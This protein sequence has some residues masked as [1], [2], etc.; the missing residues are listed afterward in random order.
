[1]AFGVRITGLPAT[2]DK[3]LWTMEAP[4]WNS[5]DLISDPRFEYAAW[6]PGYDDYAAVLTVDETK[7]L[8][9][10]YTPNATHDHWKKPMRGLKQ[11]LGSRDGHLDRVQIT[12]FEWSSGF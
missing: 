2:G 5:D 1:M 8:A 9:A 10:K 4:W 3:A 7:E 6:C 11:K 12:V